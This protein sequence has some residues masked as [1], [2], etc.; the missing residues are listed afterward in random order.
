MAEGAKRG[1]NCVWS[2]GNPC[3]AESCIFGRAS[4]SFASL[5]IARKVCHIMIDG[6]E[7][8]GNLNG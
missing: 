5:T 7:V 2:M 4:T 6:M 3:G 8:S 1:F